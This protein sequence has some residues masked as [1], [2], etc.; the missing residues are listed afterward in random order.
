MSKGATQCQDENW[1]DWEES[2][3][4]L[5]DWLT[6]CSNEIVNVCLAVFLAIC[7]MGDS[8]CSSF[9]Q[10]WRF[11]NHEGDDKRKGTENAG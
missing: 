3:D 10:T 11:E 5:I 8:G 6:D 4:L 2:N 7:W 1:M 9:R